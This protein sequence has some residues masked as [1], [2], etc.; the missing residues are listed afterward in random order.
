MQWI[1][2]IALGFITLFLLLM[3]VAGLRESRPR[4]AGISVICLIPVCLI[5]VLCLRAPD[6]I[7]R[8]VLSAIGLAFLLNAIVALIPWFPPIQS[9]DL[10]HAERFDER[11]HMF[12]RANLK[13]HPDLY[14]RHY[15]AH[16]DHLK[17]DEE[18]HALPGLGAPG[19]K[20][21]DSLFSLLPDAA[22][23]MLDRSADLQNNRPRAVAEQD[24]EPA[25]IRHAI[26]LLGDRKSVV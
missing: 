18:I 2:L 23:S 10:T 7:P 20:F 22:F 6:Q 16:P 19:G 3:L 9:P 25:G 26:R 11:N 24:K 4:I 17:A 5:A 14:R 1:G 13:D 8:W 15:E 12:A 21:H